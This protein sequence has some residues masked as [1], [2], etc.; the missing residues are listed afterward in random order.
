MEMMVKAEADFRDP[1]FFQE[2]KTK[3]HFLKHTFKIT[4]TGLSSCQTEY[5]QVHPE[6]LKFQCNNLKLC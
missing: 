1:S 5:A 3:I 2:T 6:L 4:V